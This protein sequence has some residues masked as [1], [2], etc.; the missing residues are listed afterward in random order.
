[1]NQNSNANKNKIHAADTM[2]FVICFVFY[3][4][5]AIT[6]QNVKNNM[7]AFASLL[8]DLELFF[9]CSNVLHL[10]VCNNE[11]FAQMYFTLQS[12]YG[13]KEGN[14][15]DSIVFDSTFKRFNLYLQFLFLESPNFTERRAC[16]ETIAIIDAPAG[17]GS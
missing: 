4:R 2:K 1:M 5:S 13:E 10:F 8:I 16:L 6:I 9:E 3:V 17:T 14:T 7:C 11:V 15:F 12:I